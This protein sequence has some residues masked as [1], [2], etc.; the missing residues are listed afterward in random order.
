MGEEVNFDFSANI[1]LKSAKNVVF[2]ILCT[3]MGK[4]KALPAPRPWLRYR[5]SVPGSSAYSPPS[6]LRLVCL[7][8]CIIKKFFRQKN[9][10][11]VTGPPLTKS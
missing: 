8:R 1:D 9:Y 2:C 5:H 3:T 6:V 4:A 7:L 10:L 11:S